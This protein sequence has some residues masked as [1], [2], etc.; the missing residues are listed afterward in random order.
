MARTDDEELQ[1]IDERDI[2]TSTVADI[3]AD[4]KLLESVKNRP[5]A[6]VGLGILALV[7]FIIMAPQYWIA[8]VIAI[9]A[10][11][12][13][14]FLSNNEPVLDI[15]EGFIVVHK[16]DE[17]EKLCI[18]PDEHLIYWQLVSSNTSLI[19]IVFVDET[20]PENALS[21]VVHTIN[22]YQASNALDR[23]H[24]E[25]AIVEIRREQSRKKSLLNRKGK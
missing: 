8:L 9:I 13:V 21:A 6:Y 5:I 24:R 16:K 18:I 15:Y 14:L 20:D 19:Q 7:V 25:K 1:V 23:Y 10:C 4:A 12:A 17:P 3:P 22:M 2:Y 11:I